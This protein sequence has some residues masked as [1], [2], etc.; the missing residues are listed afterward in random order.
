MKKHEFLSQLRS[1]LENN[2]DGQ[3][4]K[5]NMDFYEEYIRNE[6]K[7]GIPEEEVISSLGD[8]WAIAKTVMLSEGMSGSEN[9][10]PNES[11]ENESSSTMKT[12]RLDSNW[13]V[14]VLIAVVVLLLLSLIPV[15]FGVLMLII[16]Y[17][18]PILLVVAIIQFFK[19]KQ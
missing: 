2:L 7:K 19:R 4:L 8:P 1:A 10:D 6:M 16:R 18:F 5:E 15:A 12:F 17:A 11:K 13:K 14:W 9:H 3:S